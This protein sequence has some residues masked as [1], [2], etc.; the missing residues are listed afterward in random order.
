MRFHLYKDRVG[1]WRWNLRSSNG[2]IIADSAEAYWNKQDAINGIQL[3]RG[4]GVH[5]PIYEA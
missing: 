5:T 4:T 2:N 3:V 1:Q